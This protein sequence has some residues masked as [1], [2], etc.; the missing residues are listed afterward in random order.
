MEYKENMTK[1]RRWEIAEQL[2]ADRLDTINARLKDVKVKD[3]FYT[4]YVKRAM[5]II[6]SL[7]ALI[8]TLP[9]NLVIGIVTFFDVGTPIFFKQQRI[10]KNGKL[11]TIVKFRNMR[12]T[13]DERGELFPPSQRVTKWGKLVRKTSLDELLNFWSILKGDMSIIGPRPLPSEYLIRY[14][15]RHKVRLAVRPGLECPPREPLDH[16]WTWQE[17]LENDIWYVENIS[18]LTD[19]K[20]CFQLVQFALDRK[21]MSA[22]SVA[23]IGTFMGY[24]LKGTAINLEQVPQEY[25]RCELEPAEDINKAILINYSEASN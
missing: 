19:I 13:V 2:A 10:G 6:L 24:D 20:M 4:R 9:I 14:N 8:V 11:F 22:R 7:M 5:D 15:N 12:N 3:T 1:A 17:R 25:I 16:V 18:I 23:K 21:N